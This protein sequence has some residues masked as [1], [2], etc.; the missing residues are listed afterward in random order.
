MPHLPGNVDDLIKSNVS[1]VLNVF[2]LLSVPWWFLEGFDDQ[3]RSRRYHLNLSLSVLNGQFHCNPQTLP[4]TSCLGDVI[5]DFFWRQTQR[6]DLGGQGRRGT[7]FPTGAPQVH[8]KK[9]R[10]S[11]SAEGAPKSQLSLRSPLGG[12]MPRASAGSKAR[13]PSRQG[14]NRSKHHVGRRPWVRPPLPKPTPH[15]FG[16]SP[17]A[18]QPSLGRSARRQTLP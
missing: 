12:K 13:H 4:I 5:T 9:E 17:A 3:G 18:G 15:R 2:L 7:D 1:T 11:A 8:W 16:G 14:E 6:A 10:I